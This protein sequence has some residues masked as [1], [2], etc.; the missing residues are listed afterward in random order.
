M[1]QRLRPRASIAGGKGSIP[2]GGAKILHA[3][4]YCSDFIIASSYFCLSVA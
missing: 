1:G 2:G 3:T 4:Q